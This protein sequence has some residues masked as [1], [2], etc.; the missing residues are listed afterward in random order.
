MKTVI[1]LQKILEQRIFITIHLMQSLSRIKIKLNYQP[2]YSF[3]KQKLKN[4]I[5]IDKTLTFNKT[6]VLVLKSVSGKC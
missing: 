3:N 6:D 2:K 5:L 4:K 1:E